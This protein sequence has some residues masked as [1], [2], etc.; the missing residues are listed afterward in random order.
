VAN[1]ERR[2]NSLF[3]F[4]KSNNHPPGCHTTGACKKLSMAKENIRRKN[5]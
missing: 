3:G 4:E 5:L 2:S 1:I